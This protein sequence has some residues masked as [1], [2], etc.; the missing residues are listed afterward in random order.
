MYNGK[1]QME[2]LDLHGNV[3]DEKE[4]TFSDAIAANLVLETSSWR[5]V[6][7]EFRVVSTQYDRVH[8][9]TEDWLLKHWIPELRPFFQRNEP[10]EFAAKISRGGDELYIRRIPDKGL[11]RTMCSKWQA[12][13]LK[14]GCV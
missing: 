5:P 10:L 6:W 3:L 7:P 14:G 12:Q 2:L 8:L 1:W 9:M 4:K 11:S 13:F